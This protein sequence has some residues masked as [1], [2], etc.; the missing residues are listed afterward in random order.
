MSKDEKFD[1]P[2]A[3]II[4]RALGPPERDFRV[5]KIVL[6]LAS[7][8]FKDMFSL[9]Q[10]TSDDPR[11]STVAEVEIVEVTD[12]AE[13]LDIVLRLIYPFVPPSFDGDLDI[14]VECLVIADKYDIKGAKSRLY[15]ALARTNV[16]QSLQ[17]YAIA[18]RFGFA[19]LVDSASL[20]ILSSVHL[21]RISELPDDFDFVSATAYH[22]LVR[23]RANYLDAVVEVIK[24][25]PLQSRC[26]NCPGGKHFAEEVFRL[27]L[28]HL[29]ITGTPVEAGPCFGAWVDVYGYNSDCEGDCVQTFIRFAISRVNKGLM[30]PGAFLPLKGIL[31]KAAG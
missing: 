5:H 17:V 6:S 30:K 21:A 23:Q 11:K 16:T 18:A 12:S 28:T 7:P 27:R 15:S 2:N 13:A 1:N 9:P 24:K 10:P 19:K 3:D 22:K 20:H 29:I 25:T 14:L 31:K 4:L 26:C 8:V